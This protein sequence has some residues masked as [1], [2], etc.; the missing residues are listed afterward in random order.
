MSCSIQEL[1]KVTIRFAGDSGDGMQLTGTLFSD[2]SAVF[3]NDLSTFPDYPSEI[4]APAGTV[5]GVSSFQVQ[6]GSVAIH[7][8]GDMVDVLIAMN[9]AALKANLSQVKRG[10][11]IV[12]DKDTWTE[13]DLKKA[14]Y[15]HN[16]LEDDT[17]EGYQVIEAPITSLTREALKGTPLDTKSQDRCKNM[18]SLG[19]MAWLYS[20]P[21][22]TTENYIHQKFKGKEA[23]VDANLK[24][25]QAGYHYIQNIEAFKSHYQIKPADISPGI[26]RQISGNQAL[27]LGM[28]AASVRAGRPLVLGSYPITPASDILHELSKHKAFNVVTVQAED[29]IAGICVAIGA[30]YAGALALTTTSG[31]GLDLKSEAL[32]LAVMTELP[33][34]IVDV[35]RG[36]PSTGLPTKTEQSDLLQALY[37]RH[38]ESPLP[39]LAASTPANCFD[40]AFE[41][42][43]IAIEH[44]TP[45]I[46]LSDGYLANGSEPWKIADISTLPAIS[47]KTPAGE[48]FQPYARDPET[49]V[50]P[51]ISPG[52]PHKEHRIG[53]L[54]KQDGSGHV[55]YEGKNHEHMVKTRAEKIARIAQHIPL[56]TLVGP[57]HGDLLII[58]WGGTYGALVTAVQE[59]QAEGHQ[60]SLAHIHYLNPFPKNLKSIF[61]SF[62]SAIVCELNSGQLYKHLL[63]QF[64]L[65]HLSSFNK[66]QGQPFHVHELKAH[67]K[68]KLTT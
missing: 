33:L 30:S 6:I 46:L 37:G 31:P 12:V 22:E 61:A 40:Y 41:A 9:P 28:M 15:T 38:G 14:D 59:L 64:P 45:V 68:K 53:G 29:E 36:G 5:A 7:T 39:V 27:A 35:Q 65:T 4:R 18:F 2:E 8:P 55:S 11:M 48:N 47:P 19:M 34:V 23:V 10:G 63:S 51:W 57:D 26:Y 56:Q 42:A 25:L 44:M 62:T 58:G 32:G 21:L 43:R 66:I 24:A 16:P 67:F 50:R 20:R 60:I 54:E 1:E 49:L 13:N 52:T 17:V 3:G